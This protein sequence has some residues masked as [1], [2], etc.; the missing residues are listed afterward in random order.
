MDVENI[1][2]GAFLM[3]ET[4][5]GDGTNK[6]IR[7]VVQLAENTS[8]EVFFINLAGVL[9]DVAQL[10]ELIRTN[11]HFDQ[12]VKDIIKFCSTQCEPQ[13]LMSRFAVNIN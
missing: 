6:Y 2:L 1:T 10:V 12:L 5:L 11:C 4:C 7:S 8:K 13:K 3:K 9:R